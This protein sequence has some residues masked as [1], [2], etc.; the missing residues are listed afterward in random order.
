[1]NRFLEELEQLPVALMDLLAFYRSG[2]RELLHT[3]AARMVGRDRA[4]F[5]GMGTSEFS[6]LAISAR[7]RPFGQQTI[8]R[9]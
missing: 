4:L 6:P 8:A 5:S 7:I 3:W 1:M 2:G 9:A